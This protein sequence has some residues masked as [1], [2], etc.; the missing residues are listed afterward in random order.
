MNIISSFISSSSISNTCICRKTDPHV[1][2]SPIMEM[3]CPSFVWSHPTSTTD[4]P[5]RWWKA[6]SMSIC[7]S[8]QHSE[9][10][11]GSPISFFPFPVSLLFGECWF[12]QCDAFVQVA[13]SREPSLFKVTISNQNGNQAH[14]YPACKYWKYFSVFRSWDSSERVVEN[15]WSIK[16]CQLKIPTSCS[17]EWQS[18]PE[19]MWASIEKDHAFLRIMKLKSFFS[20]QRPGSRWS[21]SG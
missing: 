1:G 16:R 5:H 3:H 20:S 18:Y 13:F 6:L 21:W 12:P 4:L 11:L 7:I 14:Q 2:I 8:R 19:A 17:W 15:Y 9:K 10:A